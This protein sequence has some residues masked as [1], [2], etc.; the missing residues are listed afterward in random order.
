M[1]LDYVPLLAAL[2]DVYRLPRS[3]ERF[4]EYLRAIVS[5]DG[6]NLGAVPLVAAN[7]M[8]KEH[9]VSLVDALLA[10]DADRL[11]A[12][13]A[14]EAA[15]RYPDVP[16][17]FPA[18]LTVSDD[19]AGGWTNRFTCEHDFRF[20]DP[21]GKRFWVTGV[22]WSSEPASERTVVQTIRE[23]VHR[24]AYVLRHGPAV[25]LRQKLVQEGAV[26]RLAGSDGPTLDAD[27]LAYTREVI[28][29]LLGAT[30]MRTTV[31]VLFGDAAGATL[32]FTPRG[33]SPWAG[34]AV[35]RADAVPA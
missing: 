34:L 1:R 2:R 18:G 14:A 4:L 29:P 31:E 27:D 7:P 17:T 20:T 30:D 24:T 21:Q 33:L 16:G 25:T 19:L 23:A 15:S 6:T 12:D 8:A 13:A 10:F 3:R 32:G 26:M 35:A 9:V 22:L 28:A 11:A 5:D